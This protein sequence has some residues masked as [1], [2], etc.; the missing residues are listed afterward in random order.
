MLAIRLTRNASDLS[1]FLAKV[2]TVCSHQIWFEHKADGSVSRTHV[3]G[4][5]EGLSVSKETLRNW[6]RFDALWA[7]TQSWDRSDW[8]FKEHYK[9]PFGKKPVDHHMITY[10]SKGKLEPVHKK[11]FDDWRIYRDAWVEPVRRQA[12]ITDKEV[13]TKDTQITQWD[14][15]DQIRRMLDPIPEPTDE[16]IIE[17]IVQVHNIHHKLLSRYKVRDFYDSYKS[18]YGHDKSSYIQSIVFLCK[19]T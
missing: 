12:K 17:K 19:K 6:L 7:P 13:P 4:L 8:S 16:E 5:I 9:S 11:G 10:M 15:L 18:Y 2:D 1:V 14:M 3:H